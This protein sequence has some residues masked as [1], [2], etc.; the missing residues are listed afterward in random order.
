MV[1]KRWSLEIYIKYR[2]AKEV[3]NKEDP[4][5]SLSKILNNAWHSKDNLKKKRFSSKQNKLT[6]S[7]VFDFYFSRYQLF[8]SFE[9]VSIQ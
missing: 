4:R 6:L 2:E 1:T 8:P 5:F 3:I 7:L 9:T